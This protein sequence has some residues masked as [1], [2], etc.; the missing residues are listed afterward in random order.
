MAPSEPSV[1]PALCALTMEHMCPKQGCTSK[2]GP[3]TCARRSWRLSI[4]TSAS[5]AALAASS[6]AFEAC[7]APSWDSRVAGAGLWLPATDASGPR[8]SAVGRGAA[9]CCEH[10][11]CSCA[12]RARSAASWPSSSWGGRKEKQATASTCQSAHSFWCINRGAET[13]TRCQC[14]HAWRLAKCA[15][16]PASLIP[17]HRAARSFAAL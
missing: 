16:L 11:S 1:H 8:L 17:S 6:S 12:V 4:C 10:C 14:E 13:G 7:S 15:L 3:R 2:H 9:A 5:A